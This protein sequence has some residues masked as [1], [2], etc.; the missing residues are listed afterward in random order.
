MNAFA[1]SV[2]NGKIDLESAYGLGT[3]ETETITEEEKKRQ[4]DAVRGR[5]GL[6]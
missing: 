5:L 6:K 1:E 2:K 3:T 4:M